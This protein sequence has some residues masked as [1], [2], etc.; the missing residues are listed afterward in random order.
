MG[1][2]VQTTNMAMPFD[3]DLVQHV[4][5]LCL[6]WPLAQLFLAARDGGTGKGSVN[7]S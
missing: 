4:A 3:F 5:P 7:L 6:Q 2:Y 1:V